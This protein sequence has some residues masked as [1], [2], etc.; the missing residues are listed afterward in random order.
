[1]GAGLLKYPGS[2]FN[3]HCLLYLGDFICFALS[4]SRAKLEFVLIG[5]TNSDQNSAQSNF[6]TQITKKNW[7]HFF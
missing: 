3:E 6:V 2:L 5:E 1:M 7:L 4:L